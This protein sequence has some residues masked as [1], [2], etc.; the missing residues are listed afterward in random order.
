M[1]A[2]QQLICCNFLTLQGLRIFSTEYQK[3]DIQINATDVT[4]EKDHLT[5][6]FKQVVQVSITNTTKNWTS[7]TFNFPAVFL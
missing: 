7:L 4:E 3:D 6:G 5:K 2:Y 1:S